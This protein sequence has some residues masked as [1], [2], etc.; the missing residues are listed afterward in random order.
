M[1]LIPGSGNPLEEGIATH[2]SILAWRAH[3]QRSQ[4]GYSPWGCKE[5]DMTEAT[6]HTLSTKPTR[7]YGTAQGSLFHVM[8]QPGWEGSLGENGYMYMAQSLHCPLETITTLLIGYTLIQNKNFFFLKPVS[9]VTYPKSPTS[10]LPK[11][12]NTRPCS[13][14]YVHRCVYVYTWITFV[15]KSKLYSIRFRIHPGV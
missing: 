9:N 15:F 14:T 5:S 10:L 2:S 13:N 8:W 6:Q 4:V 1:C 7:T 12:S 11:Y 3:G